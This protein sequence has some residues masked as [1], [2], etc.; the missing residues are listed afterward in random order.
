MAD[1]EL[2]VKM[3]QLRGAENLYNTNSSLFVVF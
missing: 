2:N 1:V 3:K